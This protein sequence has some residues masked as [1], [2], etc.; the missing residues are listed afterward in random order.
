MGLPWRRIHSGTAEGKQCLLRG[1]LPI[2][3]RIARR[4]ADP[5]A[6]QRI[7]LP[8]VRAFTQQAAAARPDLIAITGDLID[9]SVAHLKDVVDPFRELKAPHGVF[10]V[11]GN[12]E[13]YENN[14]DTVDRLMAEAAEAAPNVALLNGAVAEYAD[15]DGRQPERVPANSPADDGQQTRPD[16]GVVK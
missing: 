4:T 5:P 8:D 14:F 2:T 11:T 6:G 9:G 3:V 1:A 12:H 7:P 16:H 15:A 10:F 13:Y